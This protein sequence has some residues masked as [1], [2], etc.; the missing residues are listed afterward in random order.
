MNFSLANVTDGLVIFF[1][2]LLNH[3]IYMVAYIF[4]ELKYSFDP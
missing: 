2:F 1:I 4:H 3:L